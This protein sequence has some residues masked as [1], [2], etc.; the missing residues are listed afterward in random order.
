MPWFCK[1]Q[2]GELIYL[3]WLLIPTRSPYLGPV[4]K[5]DNEMVYGDKKE[6]EKVGVSNYEAYNYIN[7]DSASGG[8]KALLTWPIYL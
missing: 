1:F 8:E 3:P 5:Y 7:P 6:N 2:K 4:I